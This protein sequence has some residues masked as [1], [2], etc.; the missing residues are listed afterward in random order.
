MQFNENYFS[1]MLKKNF[2]GFYKA[3]KIILNKAWVRLLRKYNVKKVLEFGCGVGFFGKHAVEGGLDY[4]G[5]DISEFSVD[6][7]KSLHGPYYGNEEIDE[8]DTVF[9][10]IIAFDV[11]EH[12]HDVDIQR[13]F[14][15]FYKKLPENG[16]MIFTTPNPESIST[17]FRK[18]NWFAFEDVTHINIQNSKYWEKI[19]RDNNFS[20]VKVGTDFPWDFQIGKYFGKTQKAA[21]TLLYKLWLLVFGPVSSNMKGDN[22]V[23]VLRKD[24]P[25]K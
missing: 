5:T 11:F 13:L 17:R 22:L 7:A 14:G 1:H 4:Y 24:R 21:V 16:M 10:C 12:I 2:M 18:E 9:D 8:V 23:F 3:D 6:K 20:I 25:N 19:S 15:I